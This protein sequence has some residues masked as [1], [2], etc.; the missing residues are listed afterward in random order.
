MD[1]VF[2]MQRELSTFPL[3]PN[4]LHKLSAAGYMTADDVKDVT[5]TELSEGKY[6]PELI[7]L[8][9]TVNLTVV[10]CVFFAHF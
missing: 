7:S 9:Q 4:Y 8:S 5:P 3:A 1:S 6:Y 10:C 2:Q